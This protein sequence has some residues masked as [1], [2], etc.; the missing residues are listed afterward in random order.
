MIY[1]TNSKQFKYYVNPNTL[2]STTNYLFRL[3]LSGTVA[4][5]KYNGFT[6]VDLVLDTINSTNSVGLLSSDIISYISLDS[7]S[8]A[9]AGQ[10]EFVMHSCQFYSTNDNINYQ[11]SN[12]DVLQK[13][14]MSKISE[15]YVSL[16]QT[17]PAV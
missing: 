11:L 7:N 2:T 9:S 17:D 10:V 1:T 6:N 8:N 14:L 3:L 13:Y 12:S 16:G 15:V 4:V 5:G